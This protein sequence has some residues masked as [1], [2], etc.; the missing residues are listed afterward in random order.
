M[1]RRRTTLAA[2]AIASTVLVAGG[3]AVAANAAA[4]SAATAATSPNSRAAAVTARQA[5][6]G[7]PMPVSPTDYTYASLLNTLD[8][9]T[10]ETTFLAGM[11]EHHGGAV[12]MADVELA[13]GSDPKVLHLAAK[14][15]TAQ[16]AQISTMTTWLQ[17]W[18]GQT[19]TQAHEASPAEGLQHQ[20]RAEM[21]AMVSHLRSMPAGSQTDMAFL[22]M[23][24][25][26]HQAATVETPPIQDKADHPQLQDLATQI[27]I[28][29]AQETALMLSWLR[30][31]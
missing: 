18:Y 5:H 15:R 29:Q 4:G 2:V 13:K 28:S 7:R 22:H 19:P 12:Q 10:L 8:G 11:I 27:T 26:H 9:A 20:M 30:N 23:M 1:S 31:S 17:Q 25:P 14:I 3:S 16:L 21:N 6:D 24:I